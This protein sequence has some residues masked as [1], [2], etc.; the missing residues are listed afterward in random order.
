MRIIKKRFLGILLSLVMVIGLMPG[1]SLTAL[2]DETTWT[3]NYLPSTS[4]NYKL[5]SNINVNSLVEL[6]SSQNISI[7]LAGHTITMA[8]D[9]SRN[10]TFYRI[11]SGATLTITDS[12]GGGKITRSG[13]T[14]D[15]SVIWVDGGTLNWEGG[16]VSDV[17]T[18]C[19]IIDVGN[20]QFN[21]TGGSFTGNHLYDGGQG[22]VRL[23]SGTSFLR[24]SGTPVITGN[25]GGNVYVSNG[26]KIEIIGM[27]SSGANISVNMQ[28]PGVFTAGYGS[29][30][31]TDSSVS[32]P[33]NFF[34]SDDS[35]NKW[36][37]WND[38]FTEARLGSKTDNPKRESAVRPY[39]IDY[40]NETATPQS[41]YELS[42]NGTTTAESPVNLS[43]IFNES[44]NP[45]IYVRKK[46]EGSQE[47]GQWEQVSLTSRPNAP[48]GINS[49]NATNSTSADGTITGVNTAMEYSVDGTTW[50]AVSDTTI[51]GLNP[52][53]YRLRVKATSSAPHGKATEVTVGSKEIILHDGQKPTP[54]T[55]LIYDGT[56]Q[57]LV[58]KPEQDL[59]EGAKEVQYAIGTDTTTPPTSGWGTS[60]PTGK[61]AGTY[62]VWYKAVGDDNH[63]STNDYCQ[64]VTI[65]PAS[66]TDASMTLSETNLDYSGSEQTVSVT[67]VKL[68]D[69]ILTADQD[70]EVTGEITGTDKGSYTVTVTGIGNYKDFVTA[71]WNIGMVIPIIDTAPTASAIT[72]GQTLNDSILSGGTAKHG[73]EEVEGTF[74]WKNAATAPAVSDSETTEYDVVFSPKD[75]ENYGVI[76]CKVK[77]AVNKSNAV[78]A[79]V[80]PNSRTYDGTEKPLV[81][82]DESTLVGGTMQYALGTATEATEQYT[83]SIPAKTDAGT[84]YVWYKVLGDSDHN[85][86]P[87]YGPVPVVI[88]PASASELTEDEKPQSN[89]P[90]TYID[91]VEQELVTAPKKLPEGYT[92]VQYSLDGGKTWSEE[93]PTGMESGDYTVSVQYLGDEN[94]ITFRGEDIKVT[95][96]RAMEMQVDFII[97]RYNGTRGLPEEIDD[98]QIKPVIHVKNGDDESVSKGLELE[99]T[100]GMESKVSVENVEFT[101]KVTDPAPGKY[102][103][104]VTGLPKS[105]YGSDK[106]YSTEGPVEGPV[107]WK[108][109]LIARGEINEKDKKIVVTVYLIF[110][111]GSRPDEIKVYAL[112]EDEVGAYRLNDDGTK[113]YLLFH[114]YDI[115]MQWLGRDELCRGYERCFH[116][117]SPFVNPFVK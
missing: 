22:A 17:Y 113:E 46:A 9:Y 62:Y 112:P 65:D 90:L 21:M 56:E 54:K 38:N 92:N 97:L 74:A 102:E 2:A 15:D 107:K 14:S 77:L 10:H 64:A 48:T 100:K 23:L 41:G 79:T 116:K 57:E 42:T 27:L 55:D 37:L 111:D 70:Y 84:Y 13:T 96:G 85:P 12:V 93:I 44:E 36:V 110:D 24:I 91:G 16:T 20:G 50:T 30:Y 69:T 99:L 26:S 18:K 117:E 75:T 82:V 105:I 39:T 32:D 49:T 33:W 101:G 58:N 61:D 60:I 81:T 63:N 31:N 53:T 94:H 72:Y 115:C 3:N 88:E 66:I 7:D 109:E 106:I 68:G 40:E 35:E 5:G 83:I 80:T 98:L 59:P 89:A 95:I 28:T 76:E 104:T 11:Q 4:G 114:T 108:Y 67:E 86:S 1:I 78:T 47:A 29:H 8:E 34:D 6:G 45:V 43:P 71:K 51:T 73:N 103:V 25:T 52:G 19:G 87:V